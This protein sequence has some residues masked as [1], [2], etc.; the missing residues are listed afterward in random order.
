MPESE[1]ASIQIPFENEGQNL[2]HLAN[3]VST[4]IRRL[5]KALLFIRN[6]AMFSRTTG[7]VD[8]PK[9]A[10]HGTAHS[11][12]VKD[13]WPAAVESVDAEKSR[14]E[15]GVNGSYVLTLKS[16]ISRS[17]EGDKFMIPEKGQRVQCLL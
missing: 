7:A 5:E 1:R 15:H 8:G 9:Q 16:R 3:K 13:A 11:H 17:R 14:N 4:N 2:N 10:P 6:P 12:D